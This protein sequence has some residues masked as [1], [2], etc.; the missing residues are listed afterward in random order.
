MGLFDVLGNTLGGIAG[1]GKRFLGGLTNQPGAEEQREGLQTQ[2]GAA[3]NFAGQGEGGYLDLG[4]QLGQEAQ[5]LR[6]IA[7]GRESVSAMQLRQALDQ[8]LSAQRSM[9]AGANPQNA[10][11]AALNASQNAA[12]LG[13]GLAGQQALAGIQERQ[14]A[15]NALVNALLGQRGQDV[16][17]A[18]GSRGNA[19]N[20]LGAITPG[21][22]PLQQFGGLIQGGLQTYLGSRGNGGQGR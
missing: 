18:L 3:G 17:V 19:I 12:R 22:S 7:R 11:M 8:N 10:A 16:Q 6:D 9:A 13:S 5:Y 14:A 1:A 2:A 20:A 4:G 15:Q 21:Q